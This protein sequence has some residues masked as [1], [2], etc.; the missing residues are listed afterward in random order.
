[1]GEKT[2]VMGE[3]SIDIGDGGSDKESEFPRRR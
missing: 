1:M 2:G 3:K